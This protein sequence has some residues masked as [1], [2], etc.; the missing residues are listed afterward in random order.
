MEGEG[1]G[2]RGGWPRA[3]LADQGQVMR[4]MDYGQSVQAAISDL[5]GP[6][7]LQSC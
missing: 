3:I 4:S 1:G 6:V 2:G 5:A 7:G